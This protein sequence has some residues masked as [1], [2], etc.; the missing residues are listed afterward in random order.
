LIRVPVVLLQVRKGQLGFV[1]ITGRIKN[2][3]PLV[4]DGFELESEMDYCQQ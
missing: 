4:A 2:R 3:E 1:M